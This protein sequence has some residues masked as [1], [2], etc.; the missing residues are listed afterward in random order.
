MD[1]ELPAAGLSLGADEG[2]TADDQPH[3]AP[4][5]LSVEADEFGRRPTLGSAM[6]SQVADRTKRLGSSIPRMVV[7]LEEHRCRPGQ[8][9]VPSD[10]AAPPSPAPPRILAHVARDAVVALEA[11]ELA[12]LGHVLK[13]GDGLVHGEHQLQGVQFPLEDDLQQFGRRP[14]LAE[15]SRD[16]PAPLLMMRFQFGHPLA[17]RLRRA[18]RAR[19]GQACL[20]Q[21]GQPAHRVLEQSHGIA[22][23]PGSG[24]A[25][26]SGDVRKDHVAGDEEP[27][28]RRG[29]PAPAPAGRAIQADMVGR[30]TLAEDDPAGVVARRDGVTLGERGEA[31]EV[32]PA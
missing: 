7:G 19:A 27:R 16:R 14:R 29:R 5:E 11:L 18:R 12:P 25:H 10:P 17:Q 9:G 26:V 6:P 32:A 28:A 4:G 15:R 30:V 1:A 3:P 22:R 31:G 8:C 21:F 23:Q 20:R 13:V 24:R 2:V